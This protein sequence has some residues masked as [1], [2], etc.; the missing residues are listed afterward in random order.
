MSSSSSTEDSLVGKD[1]AK[2]DAEKDEGSGDEEVEDE[3][4]SEQQQ[5]ARA[6]VFKKVNIIYKLR[7]YRYFSYGKIQH[8]G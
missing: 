8:R 4:N 2:E 1:K 7:G 6:T 3:C 5:L